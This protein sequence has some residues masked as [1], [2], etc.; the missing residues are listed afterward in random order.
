MVEKGMK[1]KPLV[2]YEVGEIVLVRHKGLGKGVKRGGRKIT[3]PKAKEGTILKINSKTHTFNIK[4]GKAVS[5]HKLEDITS[6]TQSKEDKRSKKRDRSQSPRQSPR[7]SPR[8]SPRRSPRRSPRQTPH[9]TP[10]QSVKKTFTP[11]FTSDVC[12]SEAEFIEILEK[13]KRFSSSRATPNSLEKLEE[14]AGK[15]GYAVRHNLGGGDCM[16]LALSQQIYHQLDLEVNA[17]EVRDMVV[18]HLQKNPRTIDGTH[19][20]NFVPEKKEWNTYL[21]EMLQKGTWGDNLMLMGAAD[22][23]EVTIK[24]ISTWSDEP[25]VIKPREKKASLRTLCLGHLAEFHYV[26]LEKKDQ[27]CRTCHQTLSVC[28]CAVSINADASDNDD[29]CRSPSLSSGD[30]SDNDGSP[31]V[32]ADFFENK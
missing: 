11:A 7:R 31:R 20:R 23:L 8:Q 18:D 9:Q 28:R 5:W 26:S 10:R 25:I 13:L 1:R 6:L 29:S 3:S 2:D 16:F 19:L 32:T 21:D 24:V 22:V 15:R 12:S 14:M 27:K 17:L 30:E 4:I